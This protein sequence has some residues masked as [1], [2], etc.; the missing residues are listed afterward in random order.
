MGIY[1]V[2]TLLSGLIY[3]ILEK[4]SN[5]YFSRKPFYKTVI[6]AG[7]ME[8]LALLT[9]SYTTEEKLNDSVLIKKIGVIRQIIYYISK[10]YASQNILMEISVELKYSQ[11]YL[12]HI[13]T[14]LTGISIKEY[15]MQMR[16]H[17]AKKM[18]KKDKTP[19]S[20]ISRNCGYINSASF[21]AEFKKRTGKTPLEYRNT[22]TNE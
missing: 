20:E 12:T 13:F 1:L 8:I 6:I 14:K 16:F 15:Q 2:A 21:T 22:S 7:C 10:N 17:Y 5:E 9:R 18:L 4:I 3:F 11:S 19:I